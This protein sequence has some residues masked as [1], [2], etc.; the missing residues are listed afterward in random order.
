MY[1]L[2]LAALAATFAL[3]PAPAFAAGGLLPEGCA[4]GQTFTKGPISVTGAFTRATPPRARSAGGYLTIHNSGAAADTLTGASTDAAAEA[5]VHEMRMNGDVME[6][7]PVEGG[8]E[9]PAGGSVSL[10]PMGYHLMLTGLTGPFVTGQCVAVTLHFARAGDVDV[11]LNIGS[12]SQAAP[13]GGENGV[14][15]MPSSM[16]MSSMPGM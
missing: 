7:S 16:D 15:D 6:M 10:D 1:R 8:L 5:A 11:E 4:T 2:R 9:I 3:L 14:M 12:L 13:P